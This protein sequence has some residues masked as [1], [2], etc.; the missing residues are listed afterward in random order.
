M[1]RKQKLKPWKTILGL[2][3]MMLVVLAVYNYPKIVRFTAVISLFEKDNIRDNFLNMEEIFPV[4]IIEAPE[5][6]WTFPYNKD[7]QLPTRFFYKDSVYNT[8]DYLKY[9]QTTGLLVMRKDT[10]L[11]EEYFNGAS[12]DETLISWSVGKSFVSAMFG[13]IVEQGLIGS[14]D[15]MVV[16]YLPKLKGTGYDN[17]RIRDVLTMSSGVR[18]DEDYHKYSSDINRMGRVFALGY[19]LDN[20]VASLSNQRKPGTFHHYVSMDTQVLGMIISKV[21]GKTMTQYLQEELWVPMGAE[22]NAEWIIDD[23]GR[24]AAFGGLNITLRDYARFGNMYNQNGFGNGKQIIDPNWVQASTHTDKAHLL[25]GDNPKSSHKFGYGYQWRLPN[26]AQDEFVGMGVY[27]QY[28][29]I[30]PKEDLVI[31]KLSS[32]HNFSTDK[33]LSTFRHLAFLQSIRS[34]FN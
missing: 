7:W 33:S 17:V 5:S 3:F 25:P 34:S 1:K 4:R 9:T 2:L 23:S 13:K 15:E 31:V 18:F 6:T 8:R 27:S 29:Y 21:T 24:E 28:I 30:C 32:N 22:H 12:E 19:S 11:Y 16:Q 10:I 26:S 20:F 14:L